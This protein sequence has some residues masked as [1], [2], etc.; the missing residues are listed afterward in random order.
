MTFLGIAWCVA[1][2][3]WV[4]LLPGYLCSR[5]LVPE[6]KGLERYGL[7]LIAGFS[8]VPLG[9]FLA[10]VAASIP[11]GVDALLLLSTVT[12]LGLGWVLT[13]GPE[14]P[15][16]D[17]GARESLSVMLL[18][19]AVTAL[20]IFGIR[21][22]DGGD[23]F[24]T[25]HHCLYVIGMYTIGNH[26]DASLPFYDAVS[27]DVM[28]YL[29]RHPTT[30]FNGLAP[31]FYEQRIG[32]APIIGTPMALYGT[33]GWLVPSIF[34]GVVT[35]VCVTLAALELKVQRAAAWIGG[36]VFTLGMQTFCGYAINENTFAVAMV[37]FLIWAALRPSLST[38]WLLMI[39][40]VSG[41]LI[42][43]RHTSALIWPA[44]ITAVAWQPGPRRQVLRGV[45]IA[46]AAAVAAAL[47]WLYINF[48]MLGNPLGHPKADPVSGVR[49]VTNEIAGF[50]FNFRALNWPFTEQWVRTPWNAF[51]TILWLPL[52]IGKSWGQIAAGLSICGWIRTYRHRRAFV[53]LVL[54]SVPH[55]LVIGWLETL[56]WEQLTYAA[57]G[58][59]PLGVTLALGVDGVLR[60]ATRRRWLVGAVAAILAVVG[61][62][63]AAETLRFPVDQ[64]RL[65][66]VGCETS[67]GET[68]G[69]KRVREWLTEPSLLPKTP[70]PRITL[71]NNTLAGFAHAGPWSHFTGEHAGRPAYQSGQVVVLSAYSEPGRKEHEF[72]LLGGPLRTAKTPVRSSLGLHQVSVQLPAERAQVT[73][74]RAGGHNAADGEQYEVKITAVGPRSELHDFTL[75]VHPWSPP[76]LNIVGYVQPSEIR[77]SDVQRIPTLRYGSDDPYEQRFIVTN[78]GPE[79]LDV[80]ELQI[81][82]DPA[83]SADHWGLLFFTYD[84]DPTS[85]ETLILSGGHDHAWIGGEGVGRSMTLRLPR[86]LLSDTLIL[87]ADPA[88]SDHTPQYGDRYGF[89][90]GP[91]DADTPVKLTLDRHW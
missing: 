31:L 33:V 5:L 8:I 90:Q 80:V 23:L 62:S 51:P 43:V 64:R 60:A 7:T 52:W 10:T 4:Q 72:Y 63:A 30:E 20:L 29:V 54:F 57:P 36:V 83:G 76:I 35:G 86:G 88:C 69:V 19:L 28:H 12:N 3:F 85:I 73:L 89:V 13:R 39:G 15:K 56:D 38:G 81:D 67:D 61:L 14:R 77:G 40:I 59:V 79:V 50:K 53:L 25:V 45:A 70:V 2:F 44:I 48:V 24:S 16:L 41:H 66:S 71:W 68:A 9:F 32:N 26:A 11:M 49:I 82:I 6:A 47:P 58:L 27:G 34:A 46:G 74:E 17:I 65:E 22:L 78:Y 84:V 91:F 1:A 87:H 18:W 55:S 37:S 75:F 21:S 42:G